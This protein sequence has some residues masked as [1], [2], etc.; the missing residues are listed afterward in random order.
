[1]ASRRS[2]SVNPGAHV[3]HGREAG[4]QRGARVHH[5]VDGLFGIGLR[6]LVVGIEVGFHGQV[7]VHI[8]EAGQHRQPAQIDHL[9]ARL[10]RKLGCR[11]DGLDRL[12]HHHKGL[13]VVQFSGLHVKQVTSAHQRTPGRRLRSRLSRQHCR[14][15]Y[16]QRCKSKILPRE[17][18]FCLQ[19]NFKGS[20][21]KE[22]VSRVSILGPGK[23]VL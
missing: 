9:I 12:T 1:M 13:A 10:R 18:L 6:Q 2:T 5:A 14:S 17:H 15:N 8:D 7:R 4:H 11:R 21:A 22:P 20:V 16:Q 3:A 23:P 19:G